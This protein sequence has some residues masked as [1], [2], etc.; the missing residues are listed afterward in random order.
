MKRLISIALSVLLL[1]SVI[2]S[3]LTVNAGAPGIT[4]VIDPGHGGVDGGSHNSTYNVN[5][6]ELNLKIAQYFK[7]ELETYDGV[8]VYMTRY[9]NNDRSLGTGGD[10]LRKRAQIAKDY[11][12]DLLISVHC[13][14][15]ES[16]TVRGAEAYYQ[17][18]S[19]FYHDL[20]VQGGK[21]ANGI[22]SKLSSLGIKNRGARVKDSTDGEIYDEDGHLADYYT[23]LNAARRAG[24]MGLIVE[25]AYINNNSDYNEF[26]SSDDKLK[27]LGV[28]DATA[29]AEHYGLHKKGQSVLA[30][31]TYAIVSMA[32]KQSVFEA[33]GNSV[34]LKPETET[35]GRFFD[36]SRLDDGTYKIINKETG[37]ALT[38]GGDKVTLA[39]YSDGNADQ[40][41]RLSG[42]NDTGS[43][44][45]G[46][47]NRFITSDYGTLRISEYGNKDEQKFLFVPISE[48]IGNK[49][50]LI[51]SRLD[52]EKVL[53]IYDASKANSANCQ[54]FT[55][56]HTD[57]QIFNM[58]YKDGY[59]TIENKGS[60][61]VLE[62]AYPSVNYGANVQQYEANGTVTQKW[63]LIK[64]S[65]GSYSFISRFNGLC[66]DLTNGSSEDFTN[67]Q[68]YGPNGS[69]A[70]KFFFVNEK[71]ADI[72][73]GAYSFGSA[74]NGGESVM[75][76]EYAS[77]KPGGNI[78]LFE[79]NGTSAQTYR[80]EKTTYGY[81]KITSALSG[82]SL[83]V[84]GG[85]YD[86]GTNLQQFTS[87]DT[88][89]QR[90]IIEKNEDSTY[91]II[92]RCNG[93][94]IDVYN[95]DTD[96]RTNIQLFTKN[97][98]KAQSFI[99]NKIFL[100]PD[101]LSRTADIADGTYVISAITEGQPVFQ[102]NKTSVGVKAETETDSQLFDVSSLNDGTYKIIN[103]ETG[104]A[105]TKSGAAV[106]LAEYAD[107][108]ADQRWTLNG[109]SGTE[110]Y[111][112]RAGDKFITADNGN[113]KTA[114]YGNK[115]SQ[116]FLF[117]KKS[118]NIGDKSV[119]IA[120]RLDSE[121]VL[122]IYDAS[123]ADGANCQIF[124]ENHTN[125]Q[126][127]NMQYK[128]GYYTIENKGSGKV[129][130]V[131]D[132]NVNYG[133][134]VQ[135]S[136]PDGAAAQKWILNQNSDG[137]YSFIS[138]FNGLCI[139]LKGGYC[140]DRTNVQ[141]FEPN[142]T[143]AQKFLL[144]N[145]SSADIA[146]GA[147]SFGSALNGGESVMDVEYASTKPGGNIW[148]F[149]K[150]GTSA[151][152]YR[153]EKT[154]Y[155]YYKITS[156]LSG[157][158]L[159]VNGGFYDDGT[160][161]QQF[162]SND[163]NSQRW[164]IEKNEDST[165]TIISRCNGKAIDVYN[166]DTDNR[167]NIQLFTKNNTKAQ[168]FILNKIFV[169]PDELSRTAD[170]ADGTYV[171][172]G[173]TDG[174]NVLQANK[175]KL[176]LKT[177]TKAESQ[178][179]D[180]TELW[181]GTYKIIN[182]KTGYALTKSG[183][184]VTLDAYTEGNTDQRWTL[185]GYSGTELYGI[186]IEENF[187][188]SDN[189]TLKISEYG[190]K[191]SQKFLFVKKKSE[192]IG[193]KSVLIASRLDASKVLDIENESIADGA[194]C[195]LYTEN[196]CDAQIFNIRYK[197]G[198]YTIENKGS[199]K[200][201]A[202]SDNGVNYGAN[203]QQS[204][205][206][207]TAAQKWILNQNSDGSYSFTSR[208][209]GLCIDLS[210]GNCYDHT[211]IQVYGPNGTEAQKFFFINAESAYIPNGIYSFG[212]ALN[213]G[214]SVMDVPNASTVP[215]GNIWLFVGNNTPAQR[216]IIER[217]EY[218]YYRITSVVSGLSLDV[219]G[220]SFDD[221]TNLQQYTSNNSLAQKWIIEKNEDSTY[222]II[223]RCNGKAIDVNNADTK[224]GTN[225][226]LFT[227]N[228][229]KAQ[230]F[231]ISGIYA[232]MGSKQ[233]GVEQMVE[234]YEK[235]SQYS[236]NEYL[237]SLGDK[238]NAAPDN[239]QDFCRLF[240]E[241]A[242]AEGVRPDVAFCQ[243]MHETGWLKFG[244]DVQP[245]QFNFAGI[246]ATGEVCGA[247]FESARIG[248]RAQIQHLK[249]YA[250]KE[251]LKNECVD[252]RFNFVRR[253]SAEYVT[254][255]SGKWAVGSSYGNKILNLIDILLFKMK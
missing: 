209:N 139:D 145:E 51:A 212:T 11:G 226:Q 10:G 43:Y 135:Q 234:F 102:A 222:T 235:N 96:N 70:Q 60:G 105:L 13:N 110:L 24:I 201:L 214:A 203:V 132:N 53:D 148:L 171:I 63:A 91:T 143:D 137:S 178:L 228:N 98:T 244:G 69:E 127:F 44:R 210:G 4:V 181:D 250:S 237:D 23:I 97:N 133:A 22:L 149:E 94:A 83:D 47:G 241:E 115:N 194:N 65:D 136:E 159:D 240:C 114:E 236:Y 186:R 123:K 86:D 176:D 76:V 172:S 199:G 189:G 93:K 46:I 221:G 174:Q 157:L 190:N 163:T 6:R 29:V 81:Y 67:V 113:L 224:N 167:T 92:S 57:A 84:N 49:S 180:V 90:W 112:I 32:D 232:I 220:E 206:N 88:N 95:A 185:N 182:K 128:N 202:V 219:S 196:H 243:S 179:F 205:P 218:G 38:K 80:I 245:N 16:G 122:D 198:Y 48:N 254:D 142:E 207:G 73:N 2:F 131:S 54:I 208:L 109:Y 77:T 45:I 106:T 104:Y 216:F 170:L 154:T 177:E 26:L 5:E 33:N 155:G 183:D 42:V 162:T 79:K 116:K 193:D 27:N 118:E 253:A 144:I 15:N 169:V 188:T 9:D 82:L 211:N 153:I 35:G 87:N 152:T 108:N 34:A 138:R 195:Q 20:H 59:Y 192:N 187:I 150:N 233:A 117:V 200:V 64:N 140:S 166:A 251:G 121:K 74:L 164:I 52:T 147:Y 103:K 107:G 151:Q 124:T 99:L 125:A 165:Y 175:T 229:T 21:L 36:V 71:S 58:Q 197:D 31:G 134:N 78:W 39:G 204:E 146:N 120:S 40:R 19:I 246:G 223:S 75:D 89:S 68:V 247:S 238:R 225:I 249:A 7:A 252:P 101:E 8:N 28:A 30:N 230:S 119:L 217:I 41:W 12:A 62:I 156:A 130:E 14:S 239:L 158:S 161:L 129:L 66:M 227:K 173:I 126:I 255:L 160:N 37:Y 248:I 50:V 168:S 100:V 1:V 25:H 141:V 231:I 213:G 56:N 61:K 18:S 191:D 3:G 242:E 55:E 111:G 215:G 184:K 85:F 17:N 72:A